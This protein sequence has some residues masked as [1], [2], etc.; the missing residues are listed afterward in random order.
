MKTRMDSW[1]GL[2][3]LFWSVHVFSDNCFSACYIVQD[4]GSQR[5][6]RRERLHCLREAGPD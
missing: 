3:L 6:V 5:H 2:P 4:A 1:T